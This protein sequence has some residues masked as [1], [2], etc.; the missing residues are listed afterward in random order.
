MT[1]L[2]KGAVM[3]G[4]AVLE[5]SSGG[6]ERSFRVLLSGIHILVIV[7]SFIHLC[8][9]WKLLLR[10]FCIF[11]ERLVVICQKSIRISFQVIQ[12]PLESRIICSCMVG[13]QH[14]ESFHVIVHIADCF[15]RCVLAGRDQLRGGRIH[16]EGVSPVPGK[17][18]D[19]S[20]AV[21]EFGIFFWSCHV[22]HLLFVRRRTFLV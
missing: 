19:A 22:H 9:G 7:E 3:D 21:W 12:G 17:L 15:Y 4:R 6:I 13:S 11:P 2:C 1:K 8:E 18:L 5:C 20:I 16:C 14:G 10:C